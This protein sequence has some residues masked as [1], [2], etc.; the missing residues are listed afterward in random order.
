MKKIFSV[1]RI[2]GEMIVCVGDDGEV[3]SIQRG[4]G[5]ALSECDVFSCRVENGRI[6]DIEP[7]PDERR[8]RA[9][10]NRRRLFELFDKNNDN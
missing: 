2:E 4:E 1:D 8:I 6:Y 10:K 3:I 9:E 5:A 7:M